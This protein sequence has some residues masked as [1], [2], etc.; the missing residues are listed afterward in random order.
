[1]RKVTWM[2]QL[3]RALA[4]EG[5]TVTEKRTVLN[6]YEEMYQDRLDEGAEEEDIIKEFGFPE[7]VAQSVRENDE[8]ART[9]EDTLKGR[10]GKIKE[11]A[12]TVTYVP[13]SY[14]VESQGYCRPSAQTVAQTAGVKSANPVQAKSERPAMS[15]VRIVVCILCAIVFFAV[16]F[17]LAVAGIAVI[18]S[19][20]ATIAFSVGV[21]LIAFGVGLVLFACGC[22]IF[23][24]AV[25]LVKAISADGG[26]K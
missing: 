9:S 10:D 19:A 17:A 20:F 4:R 18:V 11:D 14:D 13:E 25:K 6:Y 26:T 23:G 24:S 22:L 7:D 5:M 1:M 15:V 21:W 8:K 16:G 2:A 3:E 12:P